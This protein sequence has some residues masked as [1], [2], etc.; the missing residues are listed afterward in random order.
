[1][2]REPKRDTRFGDN[3]YSYKPK[4]G[5][6]AKSVELDSPKPFACA[7]ELQIS[8]F[9]L[10]TSGAVALTGSRTYGRVGLFCR[11]LRFSR[12]FSCFSRSLSNFCCCF[13]RFWYR[14]FAFLLLFFAF[15]R[16]FSLFFCFCVFR[17]V[18][19]VFRVV[20]AFFVLF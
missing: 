9:L 3:F 19:C 5:N 14:F 1:M 8:A 16:C 4:T 18:F 13:S 17:V 15:F 10:R 12:R 7:E 20:F 2:G 11:F 6:Y